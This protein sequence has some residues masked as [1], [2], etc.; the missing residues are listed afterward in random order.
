[1]KQ[2]P[3]PM[4]FATRVRCGLAVFC[5]V[6]F[7]LGG[8]FVSLVL[9]LISPFL[10]EKKRVKAGSRVLQSSW[11]LMCLLL[12]MTRNLSL[13]VPERDAMAH[14][15]GSIIVANHPSLIDVVI[16]ASIIPYCKLVVSPKLM[17]WRF[18]RPILRGLCIINNGDTAYFMQQAETCLKQ[19]FNI[20]IFPEGTR[21]TPG[22][23]SRMQRG[24]FHVA[25]LT[26]CPLYPIH[27]HTDMP[28]LTK[29]YPWWYVGERCPR[30]TLTLTPPIHAKMQPGE[31]RHGAAIRV[32]REVAARILPEQTGGA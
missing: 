3:P 9:L 1:M 14:I 17:R 25:L 31:S 26:G 11:K 7:G 18:L 4:S 23:A 13:R 22:V 24:S 30:F 10:S 27:I 2:V 6:C 32:C 12:R 20:I 16:L 21:T 5:Y 19:G 8:T 28:F 29:E 15:R